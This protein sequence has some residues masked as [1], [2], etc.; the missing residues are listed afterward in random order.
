MLKI[1]ITG[2]IGS[3]KTTVCRIFENLG[4]KVFY[5]DVEGRKLLNENEELKIAVRKKFGKDMFHINGELD[6]ARMAALVFND[7]KALEKL[8]TLVHPKVNEVFKKWL[9]LHNKKPY[10]L[11]EAAILFET[12]NFYDL[13]KVINV[14]APKEVRIQRVMKRDGVTREDVEKRIRHQYS[15]EERNRLADYIIMNEDENELLPQIMELHEIFLNEV[16]TRIK[17]PLKRK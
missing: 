2:G 4:V 11:K 14:F 12:G 16:R 15:D 5:A 13:D 9:E 6:R 1:G 17:I 7:A 3:G 8:S 10:I